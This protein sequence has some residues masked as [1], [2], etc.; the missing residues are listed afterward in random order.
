MDQDSGHRFE[1]MLVVRPDNK[2]EKLL[3]YQTLMVRCWY[4]LTSDHT[5]DMHV[6]GS[7]VVCSER[8]RVIDLGIIGVEFQ[9][10]FQVGQVKQSNTGVKQSKGQVKSHLGVIRMSGIFLIFFWVPPDMARL[11]KT[12][13]GCP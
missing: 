2:F 9:E 5:P 1:T 8:S 11:A 12:R 6:G 13:T 10:E 3:G 4:C 7:R